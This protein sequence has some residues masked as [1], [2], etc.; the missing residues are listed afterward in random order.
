MIGITEQIPNKSFFAIKY[1][2]RNILLMKIKYKYTK[3]LNLV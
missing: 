3:N 1:I 2:E